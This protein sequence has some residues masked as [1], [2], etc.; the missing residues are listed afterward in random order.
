VYICGIRWQKS[1]FLS[2]ALTIESGS[3]AIYY[4][5]VDQD[6]RLILLELEEKIDRIFSAVESLRSVSSAGKPQRELVEEI[7]RD[8]HSLKASAATQQMEELTHVAHEFENLLHALRI[9]RIEFDDEI[10]TILE[11]TAEV[12]FETLSQTR[13]STGRT[14]LLERLKQISNA[15]PKRQRAEVEIVLNS[16]PSDIC[17]ALNDQERHKL[18]ESLAEGAHL[19]LV[20]TNFETVDF[21]RQFHELKERLAARGELISTAPTVAADRADRIDFRILYTQQAPIEEVKSELLTFSDVS[22][23]EVRGLATSSVAAPSA[24]SIPAHNDPFADKP[25]FI[26]VG[27]NELDRVISSAY[28]LL[29]QADETLE[30]AAESHADFESAARD[31]RESCLKLAADIVE[32]RMVSVD[33]VLQR[34]VRAGRAAARA[35]GKEIDFELQ[36][37]D[38]L[39]DKSLSDAIIDPLIH[40]VRNAVDHGIED[41]AQRTT[42]GKMLRG[43][44]RIKAAMSQG[45]PQITVTD[46]GRGIDPVLISEAAARLE[47]ER[48]PVALGL[49]HSLR[50]IFRPGFS[51]NSDISNISGRGVGLDVVET[52][53]EKLGGEIRVSSEP[54]LG[55]SFQIRVPVTFGL[56]EA[57]VVRSG[58][59]RY[60]LDASK[61]VP[62]GDFMPREHQPLTL[63][64]LDEL[65]GHS[66]EVDTD[67]PRTLLVCEYPTEADDGKTTTLERFGLLV[68]GVEKR[69]KVLVRNLGSHSARWFGVAGATE[70]PDGSV[71]LLL[72]LPRLFK[73]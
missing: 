60:A 46:D 38:L 51:T 32:L 49:D 66:S 55:S 6:Q 22:V 63:L 4:R 36:G 26:R 56:L 64:A 27:L 16:L 34:A 69:E 53:I 12:L 7:F 52:T 65:L 15:P 31:M 42:A 70:L 28:L 68:D 41:S 3:L 37:E 59:N 13:D 54:G 8:V 57:V 17:A 62:A 20:S 50:M 43:R 11:E 25:D 9:G 24:A 44:V 18:Q 48:E 58:Q 21:D 72:D 33:R 30:Q 2:L 40:L 29:R 10:L 47:I 1:G 35:C 14:P 23:T 73:K 39:L 71:A 67:R 5:A 45:Q 19:Y 61:V